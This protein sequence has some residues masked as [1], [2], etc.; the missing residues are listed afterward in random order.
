MKI[1]GYSG[2]A[3]DSLGYHN[4]MA[5]TTVDKDNDVHSG[6]CAVNFK[7]AWWYKYCGL[8]N[9][10]GHNYG[11]GDKIPQYTGISWY[12]FTSYD[13]SLKSVHMAIRPMT[14]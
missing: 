3:G 8:S 14:N 13:Y 2:T 9:L 5:F 10:N 4:T 1:G 7:G 11:N 12:H 6:N